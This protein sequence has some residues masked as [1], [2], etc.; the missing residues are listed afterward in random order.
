MSDN[1]TFDRQA[2]LAECEQLI[3]FLEE[4]Y[5]YKG[6][7]EPRHIQAK[8]ARKL[9]SEYFNTV[10]TL[11]LSR[12]P[13][14][15]KVNTFSIDTVGLDG[16]WW[17]FPSQRPGLKQ[18]NLCPHFL[19]LLGAVKLH[20]PVYKSSLQVEPG[21]EAPFV[22]SDMI[23]HETVKVVLSQVKVGDSIAYP[24][25]YYSEAPPVLTSEYSTGAEASFCIVRFPDSSEQERLEM[26]PTWGQDFYEWIDKNGKRHATDAYLFDRD[27]D[28]EIAPWIESNKLLW[29]GPED[30]SLTLHSTLDDCPYLELPGI[31]YF[32]WVVNG[33]VRYY[34]N[35]DSL[36]SEDGE[37]WMTKEEYRQ[38][39]RARRA[40]QNKS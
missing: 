40:Q 10:P 14:C 4:K 18:Y 16:L 33:A 2:L 11:P 36:Y 8:R 27:C 34:Q 21:P 32:Q 25:F 23:Q 1:T 13:F 12:C 3:Q 35:H 31:R 19:N 24:I 39:R 20:Y 6:T 26:P 17:T 29:I 30:E 37:T 22:V 28:F 5:G 9:I 7:G 15:E 38:V